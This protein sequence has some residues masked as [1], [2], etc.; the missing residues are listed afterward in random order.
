MRRMLLVLALLLAGIA[1]SPPS[2]AQVACGDAP[3]VARI[4]TDLQ[5]AINA[6]RAKAG[7]GRVALHARATTAA[8]K[9]GCDMVAYGYFSHTGRDGSTP[10]IRLK[11]EGYDACFTAENLALGHTNVPW[12]MRDWMNSPG[13]RANI[14]DKR[15]LHIGVA[16]VKPE[17]ATRPIYWVLMLARPC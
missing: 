6:E 13:H 11:R 4:R 12:V 8:R 1:A 7:V 2:H 9:H 17:K 14:L 16:A 15:A 10:M 3:N 5:A